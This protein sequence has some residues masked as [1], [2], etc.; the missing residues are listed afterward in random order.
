MGHLCADRGV[1]AV[2][3]REIPVREFDPDGDLMAWAEEL[4]LVGLVGPIDPPRAEARAAIATC[5][6]AG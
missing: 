3:G 2:A 4:T 1:I 6:R 5:R